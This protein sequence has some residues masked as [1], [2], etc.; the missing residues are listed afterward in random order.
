[1]LLAEKYRDKKIKVV[2]EDAGMS[3]VMRGIFEGE[4]DHIIMLSL[5]DGR[6]IAIGKKD[7]CKITEIRDDENEQ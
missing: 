6:S 1:M 5:F 4:D 3:K 2:F 7:I